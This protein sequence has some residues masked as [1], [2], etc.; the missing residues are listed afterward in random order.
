MNDCNCKVSLCAGANLYLPWA[1]LLVG[2][3]AGFVYA[4]V[5]SLMIRLANM[6]SIYENK[7]RYQMILQV[8]KK[9]WFSGVVSTT[10]WMQWL[11]MLE[12]V[13][14]DMIYEIICH[15]C[16]P[17]LMQYWCL[18]ISKNG[19]DYGN[20]RPLGTPLCPFLHVCKPTSWRAGDPL[21]WWNFICFQFIDTKKTFSSNPPKRPSLKHSWLMVFIHRWHS[22]SMDCPWYPLRWHRC[23]PRLVN[24]ILFFYESQQTCKWSL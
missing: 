23:N 5:H 7:L 17:I 2:A 18:M 9:C 14:I 10:P 4:G 12:E 11:Y 3:G 16:L 8:D 24:I 13:S 19:N 20:S 21:R 22:P 6:G 1:A 15:P